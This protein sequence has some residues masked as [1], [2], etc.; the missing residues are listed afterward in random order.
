MAT[1]IATAADDSKARFVRVRAFW[2]RIA[3]EPAEGIWPFSLVAAL[4][5]VPALWLLFGL[6][7]WGAHAAAGWPDAKSAGGVVYLVAAV[8]LIPV[9]LVLLD[10]L[11]RRRA[12]ITTRFGG[13]DFS[14]SETATRAAPLQFDVPGAEGA[15][16]NESTVKLIHELLGGTKTAQVLHLDLGAG[17]KWWMTR[18]FALCVGAVDAGAPEALVFIGSRGESGRTQE[19]AFLGWIGTRNALRVLLIERPELRATRDR[20][21]AIA[22]LVEE[23]TVSP[24]AAPVAATAPPPGIPQHVWTAV[25]DYTGRPDFAGLGADTGLRVLLR[26]LGHGENDAIAAGGPEPVTRGTL[27]LFGESLYTETIDTTW[28]VEQKVEAILRARGRFVG[29][30]TDGRFVRLLDRAV[31]QIDLLRQLALPQPASA[32]RS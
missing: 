1:T 13:L 15:A 8:G 9:W 18:L 19:G 23:A 21:R 7:L 14:K 29:E 24:P 17:D 3:R 26:E 4:I 12:V 32:Q 10:S 31:V 5:V 30:T 22:R 16:I 20:S 11:A 28:P 6:V 2:A 27:T 25:A